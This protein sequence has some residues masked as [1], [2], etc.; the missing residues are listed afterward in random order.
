MKGSFVKQGM[1]ASIAGIP[2]IDL[3][4]LA[5]ALVKTKLFFIKLSRKGVALFL[6]P[7]PVYSFEKLSSIKIT[8]LLLLNN[9]PSNFL[10]GLI[11]ANAFSLEVKLYS[12]SPAR[13]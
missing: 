7:I 1:E 9:F 11:A 12:S 2:S 8:M 4:P 5:Q 10:K 13:L 3:V 6:F